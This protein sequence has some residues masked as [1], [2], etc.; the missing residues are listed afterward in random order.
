M[1]IHQGPS[2]APTLSSVTA[3]VDKWITIPA[4][5]FGSSYTDPLGLWDVPSG[6]AYIY[7]T[8]DGQEKI[9]PIVLGT[10]S[11][12]NNVRVEYQGRTAADGVGLEFVYRGP[13]DTAWTPVAPSNYT[14]A[15]QVVVGPASIPATTI[16]AGI[17][18]GIRITS[19]VVGTGWL[20]VF[21]VGYH[22]TSRSL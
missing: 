12:V 3:T 21:S 2:M 14:S 6:G 15:A 18:Y 8:A 22:T 13:T 7:T 9:F 11:V 16:V 1:A 17:D 4:A 10:G 19:L 5:G 20:K